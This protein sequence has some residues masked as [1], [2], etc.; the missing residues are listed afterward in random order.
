M[1]TAE[2]SEACVV[3]TIVLGISP[4]EHSLVLV[5]LRWVSSLGTVI[6]LGVAGHGIK[7]FVVTGQV[8]YATEP[9][10][11]WS[12]TSGTW[13]KLESWENES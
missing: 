12:L 11:Q 1:A 6:V 5:R 13:N 8:S 4:S 2:S 10:R 3:V 9:W 7:W